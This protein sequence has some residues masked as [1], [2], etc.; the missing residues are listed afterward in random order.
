MSK[1]GV[2]P[3]VDRQGDLKVC[4]FNALSKANCRGLMGKKFLAG[5]EVDVIQ[6]EMTIVLLNEFK[7]KY[8]LRKGAIQGV[9]VGTLSR[10]IEIN[11]SYVWLAHTSKFGLCLYQSA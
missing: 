6:D 8:L 11:S 5:H 1:P 2:F 7:V 3:K 10:Q 9:K 4:T